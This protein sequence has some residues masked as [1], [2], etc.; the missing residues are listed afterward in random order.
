MCEED[1]DRFFVSK[2]VSS[3]ERFPFFDIHELCDGIS[4][5]LQWSVKYVSYDFDFQCAVIQPKCERTF[6]IKI[7][8]RCLC[9]C[10][11]HAFFSDKT[12]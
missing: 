3:R 10:H 4:I 5:F 7:D 6:V 2:W 12:T 9:T 8:D 11:M 1:F